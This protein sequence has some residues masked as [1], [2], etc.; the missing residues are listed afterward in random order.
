MQAFYKKLLYST[1]EYG[2]G[3]DRQVELEESKLLRTEMYDCA[4][5]KGANLIDYHLRII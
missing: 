4:A 2:Q 1:L 5:T 3:Y